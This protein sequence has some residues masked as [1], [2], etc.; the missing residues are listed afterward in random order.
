[1]TIISQGAEAIL[2]LDEGYIYKKRIAKTY[3]VQEIDDLLR[4][5]RT[6]REI[7]VLKKVAELGVRVPK[8]YRFDDPFVIKMDWIDSVRLRDFI[9][10]DKNNGFK[11]L[12]IIGSWIAKLHEKFIIHGDL[13]TSNI[14][15]D[16]NHNLFLIDFGLSFSSGKIE[17][18]AVDI[19]LLEQALES[20]HYLVKDKLF[21][22]FLKGYSSFSKYKEVIDRLETVRSRGRNKH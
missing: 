7:K 2:E 9:L 1:M 5:T 14:L 16:K 11:E 22:S 17:D 19:H 6:K 13:T 4:K 21:E 10:S 12:E 20:T 8:V 15:I 3:R 18:M